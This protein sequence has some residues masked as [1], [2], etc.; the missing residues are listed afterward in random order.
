M[1]DGD[2]SSAPAPT[3]WPARRRWRRRGVEVT[4]LEAAE[5]IGG[6]TRSA[7]LT[8]AGPA[9]RR[10][11]GG[12]PD[13][14]RPRRSS[15]SL[16]LE[17]ARA[18]VAPGP[19][20]TSR[21]RST[22]AAPRRCCARSRRRPPGSAPTARPGGGSSAARRRDFDALDED[23]LRP[24]LHLPRHPLLLARFGLPALRAGD[25]ARPRAATTP[26]GAG[27][28]RR[29]R[30]PR[31]QPADPAAQRRGRDGADLRLPPL[32]LAG[33]A[34]RLAGDRRR[35]GRG[36]C[37]STAA[38]SRPG[39]RVRSL[40]EL[41]AA[42]AV[43][44]D[45]A[46]GARSP[47]SPATGCP[48]GSPAPTAA[49]S[50]APAPSRSTSRSRAGCRGRTRPAAGPAPST[51]SAPSR[52]SSPPSATSTAA[53]CRSGPSSSSASS[54]SPTPRA[55]AGDVHPVWAYAH[56]PNGYDGDA[57]EAVLDQIERFAPGLRERIVATRRPLARP[58]SRPT[59][60]TT[61]A[62]TSSPAPTRRCRR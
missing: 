18:R 54:T 5:T 19:R 27:A 33:R 12:A 50:T 49:T 61:S 23:I 1:S 14:R 2:R 40:A 4:V 53:A 26:R 45:L 36:R 51:R 16:G 24:L 13:G 43:V 55:R 56:V 48:A 6:G 58:S 39:V 25:A 20:S 15:R 7:E 11:L 22:T 47:R 8:A 62:A 17:R 46:P 37:A 31:L 57:T 59:T 38:G 3:G 41:P 9:P 10:L 52:R 44:F 35:A 21:T 30:R 42:D 60:P 29:R 32:R 28:V 34:R